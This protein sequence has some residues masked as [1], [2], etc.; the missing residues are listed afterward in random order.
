MVGSWADNENQSLLSLSIYYS[1]IP[2]INDDMLLGTVRHGMNQYA[3]SG[4]VQTD[5]GWDYFNA[6]LAKSWRLENISKIANI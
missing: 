3:F 2:Q 6:P 5:N 4:T 1:A